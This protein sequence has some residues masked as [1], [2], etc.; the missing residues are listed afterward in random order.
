MGSSDGYLE[1]SGAEHLAALSPLGW[2]QCAPV[3]GPQG[4]RE[5]RWRPQALNAAVA[6][7]LNVLKAARQR[8]GRRCA[9]GG[10]QGFTGAPWVTTAVPSPAEVL[11][12]FLGMVSR[13]LPLRVPPGLGRCESDPSQPFPA[14]AGLLWEPL[15]H[16]NATV[17]SS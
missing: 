4:V 7:V 16:V 8:W 15:A 9:F 6:E 13:A 11:R 14:V 5:G 10:I 1:L 12:R 3:L 2:W 17:C